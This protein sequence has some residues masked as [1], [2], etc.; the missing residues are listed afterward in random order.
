[1]AILHV[2]AKWNHLGIFL[3][4][5]IMKNISNFSEICVSVIVLCLFLG[6]PWVD[7]FVAF[8]GHNH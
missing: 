2:L 3:V 7:L 4:D 6:M 1:M 5:G 8:P